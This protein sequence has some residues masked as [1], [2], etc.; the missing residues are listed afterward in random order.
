[1]ANQREEV[2][3][4]LNALANR[5]CATESEEE[6]DNLFREKIPRDN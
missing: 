2:V 6:I 4:A 5:F 1:M 3:E